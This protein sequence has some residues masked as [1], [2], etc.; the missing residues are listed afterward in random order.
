MAGSRPITPS[1]AS[2]ITMSS[3]SSREMSTR[4]RASPNLRIPM[5]KH[6]LQDSHR[7]E[8]GLP[9]QIVEGLHRRWKYLEGAIPCSRKT[10]DSHHGSRTT[11]FRERLLEKL[12]RLQLSPM[13]YD[14]QGRPRRPA[15]SPPPKETVAFLLWSAWNSFILRQAREDLEGLYTEPPPSPPYTHLSQLKAIQPTT[16]Y[17]AHLLG[18]EAEELRW[19]AI[20][21]VV[22]T[23]YEAKPS[24]TGQSKDKPKTPGGFKGKVSALR[25]RLL[26]PSKSKTRR[27]KTCPAPNLD[28]SSPPAPVP[29]PPKFTRS[30]TVH[31][32]VSIP[33]VPHGYEGFRPMRHPGVLQAINTDVGEEVPIR[34]GTPHKVS[35]SS[36]DTAVSAYRSELEAKSFDAMP[37]V[38]LKSPGN[39]TPGLKRSNAVRTPRDLAR[40]LSSKGP[41]P[42]SLRRSNAVI[43]KELL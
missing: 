1:S 20:G 43:Y 34:Q 25:E 3:V 36:V 38:D 10:P 15:E 30:S 5:P 24:S 4:K 11:V 39:P 16:Q 23:D 19:K 27:S 17:M 9:P 33:Q 29:V 12:P 7:V 41:P 6:D 13:S 14:P 18:V 40:P 28:P 42:I 37:K 26:R 31:P 22:D 2:D 32:E 21:L 35:N 8:A